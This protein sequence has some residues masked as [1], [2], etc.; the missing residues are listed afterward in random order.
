MAVAVVGLLLPAARG[1]NVLQTFF[2]PL[3]EDEMQ[4]TLNAIDAYRGYIGDEMQSA[5]SMVVGT[6]GTVLYYDHWE[7]GFEDD[8]T[9]PT[10]T[11]SQVWG[12]ANLENG[13]PPG[14]PDDVLS[15][16][17]VVRLESTID[18]TRNSVVIEYDGRDKVSTTLPIAILQYLEWKIDP[19]VAAASLIQI[20]LICVAMVV[21]DRYVKLSRVV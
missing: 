10:Q 16:G 7:D 12:D 20:V 11:T 1:A 5:I 15:A 17:D 4:I 9:A 14:F 18:V 8:I 21:T 19:T 3:P 6:D 13:Y 2:V